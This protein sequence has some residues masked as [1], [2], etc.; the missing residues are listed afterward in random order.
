MTDAPQRWL[1]VAGESRKCRRHPGTR[2]GNARPA[3]ALGNA[4]SP[5]LTEQIGE[6]VGSILEFAR[7]AFRRIPLGLTPSAEFL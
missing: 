6:D 4:P 1:A 3:C 5:V 7:S 2:P